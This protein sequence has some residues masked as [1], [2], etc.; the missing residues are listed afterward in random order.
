MASESEGAETSS[1]V[2]F[3]GKI[4]EKLAALVVVPSYHDHSFVPFLIMQVSLL[5]LRDQSQ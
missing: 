4:E 5:A 2:L 1:F 3:L